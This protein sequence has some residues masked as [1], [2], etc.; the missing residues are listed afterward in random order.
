MSELRLIERSNS[1]TCNYWQQSETVR[2]FL[3]KYG[4]TFVNALP[5]Q[6]FIGYTSMDKDGNASTN[7]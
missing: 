3:F 4:H 2:L 5:F 1:R 7:A 6:G